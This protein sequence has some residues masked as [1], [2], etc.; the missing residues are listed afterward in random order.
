[1]VFLCSEAA[2]FITGTVL[3]VDGGYTAK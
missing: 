2:G 3:P 1:M